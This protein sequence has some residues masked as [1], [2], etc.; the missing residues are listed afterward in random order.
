[1][2][3]VGILALQ[4]DVREHAG[5]LAAL[6]AEPVEVRSADD[7]AGVDGLV[8]PGGESTT[9]SLLLGS[10]G[11]FDVVAERLGDGMPAFGT[12]A[13]MILL[14]AHVLDGRPDQRSFG[15]VD[16]KVRR[17]AFG[18]QVDSF[19]TALDVEGVAGGPVDAVFIRAPFVEEAGPDVEVLASVDGHP[20][21]V[22]QGPVLAAAFHPELSGDLRVHQLFLGGL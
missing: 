1:M 22:R 18:R 12:C 3:K 5:A 21:L 15:V 19:E 17:N 10:S 16:I 14:A 20:V 9:M 6:G 2:G 4:G 7:L 13:G 11:L 8:L